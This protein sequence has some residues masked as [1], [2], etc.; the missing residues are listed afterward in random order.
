D[1]RYP[2]ADVLRDELRAWLLGLARPYGAKEA[3]EE[4]AEL[5]KEASDL[6]GLAAHAGVER[7][8]LPVPPDMDSDDFH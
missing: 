7:G 2:S 3:E 6:R 4:L 5:L 1:E 8:V